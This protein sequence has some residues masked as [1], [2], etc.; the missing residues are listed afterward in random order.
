MLSYSQRNI[1]KYIDYMES[2]EPVYPIVKYVSVFR[3]LKNSNESIQEYK[4]R[5]DDI[6]RI[7][8]KN[9]LSNNTFHIKGQR[10][11]WSKDLNILN[12]KDTKLSGYNSVL[13]DDVD[14]EYFTDIIMNTDDDSQHLTTT[15]DIEKII[16]LINTNIDESTNPLKNLGYYD[17]N[18]GPYF[19]YNYK[20]SV[21]TAGL[22]P[23]ENDDKT[24]TLWMDKTD[25]ANIYKFIDALFK[26]VESKYIKNM[27]IAY[28]F[29]VEE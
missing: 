23:E 9:V 27:E 12:E 16:D 5:V 4:K 13:C 21:K 17:K 11:N 22:F 19:G 26:N 3:V 25:E 20:S 24:Y 1:Q 8:N 18:S 14:E 2:V 29:I 15:E 7:I 28:G 10:T 6:V